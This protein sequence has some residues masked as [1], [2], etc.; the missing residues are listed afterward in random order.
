M[1]H[2]ET[3]T[4]AYKNGWRSNYWCSLSLLTSLL[5]KSDTKWKLFLLLLPINSGNHDISRVTIQL[6]LKEAPLKLWCCVW[7]LE[8][9]ALKGS[10]CHGHRTCPQQPCGH[11]QSLVAKHQSPAW[12]PWRVL[13]APFKFDVAWGPCVR[14]CLGC[15]R[16]QQRDRDVTPCH[17]WLAL[18]TGHPPAPSQQHGQWGQ[19]QSKTGQQNALS[20]PETWGAYP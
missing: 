19:G 14:S 17:S 13:G 16:W 20:V 3:Y 9:C 5:F 4:G 2:T 8:G 7:Q 1:V 18:S 15:S 10:S 6:D 12:G 11:L